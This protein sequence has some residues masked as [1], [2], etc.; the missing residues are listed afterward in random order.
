MLVGVMCVGWCDVCWD[1]CLYYLWC[2]SMYVYSFCR[3]QFHDLMDLKISL[4]TELEHYRSILLSEEVRLGISSP[5]RERLTG[6]LD[7]AK[8]RL[9]LV[10]ESDSDDEDDGGAHAGDKRRR[11]TAASR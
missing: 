9:D 2:G 8:R 6:R 11:T 4:Q 5:D 1:V 3:D 7:D 10:G